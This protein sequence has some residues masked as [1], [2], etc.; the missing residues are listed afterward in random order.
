MTAKPRVKVRKEASR[1]SDHPLD[2]EMLAKH[3]KRRTRTFPFELECLDDLA[4]KLTVALNAVLSVGVCPDWDKGRSRSSVQ[5]KAP[6]SLPHHPK[7][8]VHL[9]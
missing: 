8:V 5:K 6:R 7:L 1:R 9:R 4:S 3:K 2:M